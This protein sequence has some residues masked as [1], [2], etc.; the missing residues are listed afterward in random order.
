[1]ARKNIINAVIASSL[2]LS[3]GVSAKEPQRICEM[4]EN[5][6]NKEYISQLT[7][8]TLDL[9]IKHDF[10]ANKCDI[11]GLKKT[12]DMYSSISLSMSLISKACESNLEDLADTYGQDAKREEKEFQNML[13]HRI[14]M[15]D[16]I[17]EPEHM[18]HDLEDLY[19]Y[20]MFERTNVY[21][22]K[23]DYLT[24]DMI[25]KL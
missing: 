8:R 2:L 17:I 18:D 10:L 23:T 1:M 5:Q 19:E 12:A 3:Q 16:I 6:K 21:M 25:Q 13:S 9:A 15:E 4:L 20:T 22:L 11:P 24:C 7:E 14:K